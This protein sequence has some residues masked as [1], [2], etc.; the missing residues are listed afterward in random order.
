MPFPRDQSG[1]FNFDEAAAEL[2]MDPNYVRFL[3]KP[4]KYT[5]YIKGS[6]YPAEY[7][8]K[9]R[10]GSNA[11]SMNHM[12]PLWR[13]DAKLHHRLRALKKDKVTTF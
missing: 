6:R 13:K 11:G 10:P 4:M 2:E 1:R 7:G 3:Y 12:F 9:S 8:R 5:L